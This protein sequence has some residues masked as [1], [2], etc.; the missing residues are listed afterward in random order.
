MLKIGTDNDT[1]MYNLTLIADYINDINTALN[2]NLPTYVWNG[3]SL[4]IT[5]P[6][7]VNDK[8]DTTGFDKDNETTG[9]KKFEEKQLDN[10]TGNLNNVDLPTVDND[11]LVTPDLE[12]TDD[13]KVEVPKFESVEETNKTD[14]P[15]DNNTQDNSSTTNS[16][17]TNTN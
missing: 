6:E 1:I 12:S 8:T 15:D 2:A 9:F 11:T 14:K 17:T 16:T 13:T 3:N 7:N 4:T 5:I 10:L